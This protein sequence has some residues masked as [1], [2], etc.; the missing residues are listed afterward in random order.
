[1]KLTIEDLKNQNLILFE[2]IS[3]SKAYNLATKNSDTDIRG[4]F[5]LPK[6][7]FYSL[8]Y[9][10][11]ISNETNDI[12]YYEIGRFIEL[13]LKN[14]PSCLE[15]LATP[16]EFV[17]QKSDL[18]N[19]LN[20]KDF[21]TN[22]IEKTFVGY[23][24]SQIKKAKGLNKKFLNPIDK[25]RKTVLDFCFIIIENKTISIKNWLT[26]NL[27][28]Q[29]YCGLSKINH[30]KDL[31]ALYYNENLNYKGIIKNDSND[32]VRLSEV[33]ENEKPVAY[34]TFLKDEY[35]TYCKQ[36]I[37]YW[38][39]M[40][41]RNEDRYTTNIEH[42]KNYDSKNMMHTIRL[43]KVAKELLETG[44]LNVKRIDDR[45]ELLSI[46]NGDFTYEEVIK[47]ANNLQKEI[48]KLAKM[49]QLKDE[50]DYSK[51]EKFLINLR[52]KLYE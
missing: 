5:Y 50:I 10:P 38:E 3:G 46:K 41:L 30:T 51:I 18:M 26:D 25:K 23:A 20:Y 19:E 52:T 28:K 36:Y 37:E 35:S 7:E 27:L 39:W 45:E 9:Q 13:L 14:N 32:D 47:M 12:V 24:L 8:D 11:Q 16:D 15:I 49:T 42:G 2:C 31:F 1:M 21:V 22:N 48:E 33:P 17:L 6:K 44:H 43:L 40:E 4:V 29:E 34:F